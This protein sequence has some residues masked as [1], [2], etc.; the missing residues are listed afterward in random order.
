MIHRMQIENAISDHHATISTININFLEG[1]WNS[2]KLN[3]RSAFIP[4][5]FRQLPQFRYVLDVVINVTSSYA[6]PH[7]LLDQDFQNLRSQTAIGLRHSV[8]KILLC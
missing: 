5:Y 2:L 4:S 8:L 1:S 3:A 7:F 6:T